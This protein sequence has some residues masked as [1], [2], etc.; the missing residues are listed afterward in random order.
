MLFA[1][2]FE[3][4]LLCYLVMSMSKWQKTREY[5]LLDV[6]LIDQISSTVLRIN[7]QQLVI[8]DS[9]FNLHLFVKLLFERV[10]YNVEV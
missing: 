3:M 6:L 2:D 4:Y 5:L 9:V 10:I 7:D 1:F 8:L